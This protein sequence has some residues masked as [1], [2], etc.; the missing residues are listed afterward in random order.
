MHH[1]LLDEASSIDIGSKRVLIGLNRGTR[2][3]EETEET[4]LEDVPRYLVGKRHRGL[5]TRPADAESKEPP[6]F[7]THSGS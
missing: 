3:G 5:N 1:R 4:G 2:H 7:I 6:A